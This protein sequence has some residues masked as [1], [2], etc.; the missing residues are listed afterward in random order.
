MVQEIGKPDVVGV[1]TTY[2]SGVPGVGA[3]NSALALMIWYVI[4]EG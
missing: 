2:P 3:F 1:A 4:S